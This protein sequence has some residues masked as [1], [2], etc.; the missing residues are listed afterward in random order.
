M[1]I[2]GFGNFCTIP[3]WPKSCVEVT[4]GVGGA[5]SCGSPTFCCKVSAADCAN[6]AGAAV[7]ITAATDPAKIKRLHV[8]ISFNLTYQINISHSVASN[9]EVVVAEVA[10]DGDHPAAA[11]YY[12]G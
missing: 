5:T 7:K 2:S 11:E 1:N 12:A 6:S 3:T 8:V 10:G 9:R 4:G